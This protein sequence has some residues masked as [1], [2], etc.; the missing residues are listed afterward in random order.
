[1]FRR[2]AHSRA[3]TYPTRGAYESEHVQR[4]VRMKGDAMPWCGARG[5]K[6]GDDVGSTRG[7]LACH[8]LRIYEQRSSASR[9]IGTQHRRCDTDAEPPHRESDARREA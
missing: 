1:M 5:M 2:S 6:C 7:P 3:T 8:A 9:G 4:D